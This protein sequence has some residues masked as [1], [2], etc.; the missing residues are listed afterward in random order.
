MKK[1]ILSIVFVLLASI[2][3]S[4]SE[5]VNTSQGKA[6]IGKEAKN[7]THSIFFYG[8]GNIVMN[9]TQAPAEEEDDIIEK[10]KN[11]VFDYRDFRTI[12][13][14]SYVNDQL[15]IT[16]DGKDYTLDYY[17]S[18]RSKI[19]DNEKFTSSFDCDDYVSKD[20][21]MR[22]AIRRST[23]QVIL[24][25]DSDRY[26]VPGPLTKEEAPEV[27]MTKLKAIYGED[28]DKEYT[29]S[30]YTQVDAPNC[31]GMVFAKS[32]YGVKTNDTI[33]VIINQQGELSYIHAK[34]MGAYYDAEKH[35]SKKEIDDALDYLKEKINGKYT[36]VKY[37][38]IIN[39]DC[40]YF[41]EAY[42]DDGDV[43]KGYEIA[44]V[45]VN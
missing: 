20:S 35:I 32:V 45:N 33:A 21:K 7:I 36:L 43:N 12:P 10:Y 13:K 31:Y 2:F 40:E 16:L 14:E 19:A 25:S 9:D 26:S 27:A 44:Y 34:M 8:S 11:V 17:R 24:Y 37:S 15:R 38:L 39:S 42:V 3:I 28:T 1:Y 5:N 6:D 22:I 30:T 41:I 18:E 23:N 29:F 4:C